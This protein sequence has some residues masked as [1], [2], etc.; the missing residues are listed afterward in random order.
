MLLVY[1]IWLPFYTYIEY[2]DIYH[3]SL[4]CYL[5]YLFHYRR[6]A[7]PNIENYNKIL[8]YV[9]NHVFTNIWVSSRSYFFA[10]VYLLEA[11]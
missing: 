7:P 2:R 6:T 3:T 8:H 10:F 11:N 1:K 5:T 9:L 4:L